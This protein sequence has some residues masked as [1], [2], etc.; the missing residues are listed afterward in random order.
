MLTLGELMF[1]IKRARCHY[2]WYKL[3]EWSWNRRSN[4]LNWVG[5]FR[6][7]LF[8]NWSQ[9][10]I[11]TLC[12]SHQRQFNEQ[13]FPLTVYRIQLKN[14]AKWL[15]LALPGV[16]ILPLRHL[17]ILIKEGMYHQRAIR[18]KNGSFDVSCDRE[19]FFV[20]GQHSPIMFWI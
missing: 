2:L 4:L 11:R 3:Y 12:I 1:A 6:L 14:T 17:L 15:Y 13:K 5:S 10:I 7:F 18:G 20:F 19:G 16:L 8:L 9:S